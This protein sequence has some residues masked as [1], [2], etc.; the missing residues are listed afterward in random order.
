MPNIN[1]GTIIE[2]SPGTEVTIAS[3][4]PII[5]HSAVQLVAPSKAGVWATFRLLGQKEF[6]WADLTGKPK[7]GYKTIIRGAGSI[8]DVFGIIDN[9]W[10]IAFATKNAKTGE[11]LVLITKAA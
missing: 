9:E 6:F 10:W 2:L 7:E 4:A 8:I 5:Y 3:P 1:S 11:D